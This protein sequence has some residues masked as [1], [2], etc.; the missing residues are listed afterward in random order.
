MASLVFTETHGAKLLVDDCRRVKID[1][2]MLVRA[3][4]TLFMFIIACKGILLMFIIM[5]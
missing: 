5:I 3:L 4:L 2:A 1:L